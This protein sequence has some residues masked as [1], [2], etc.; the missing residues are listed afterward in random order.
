[1][2]GLSQSKYTTKADELFKDESYFEAIPA[3]QKAYTSESSAVQKARIVFQ[4]AESYR[5]TSQIDQARQW[6]EKSINSKHPDPMQYYYFAEMLKRK[7]DLDG[8]KEHYMNFKKRKPNDDRWK[9]GLKSLELAKKWKEDPSRYIVENVLPIN[10]SAR[11]FSPTFMDKKNSQIVFTSGR[12]GSSGDAVDKR[13][14]ENFTDLWVTLQDKKGKWSEP[15][16]VEG[17]INTEHNEGSAVFDYKRKDM[18]FTRCEYEKKEYKGCEIYKSMVLNGKFKDPV[19]VTE[20]SGTNEGKNTYGHPAISKKGDALVFASDR[21]GGV[22]GKDLWIIT[23]DKRTKKWSAPKNMG[24]KVNT[25]G[26]EMYPFI[27]SDGK[28]YFS[29]DGHV[30]M[31]GLDIFESDYIGNYRWGNVKNME[32]P[33]NSEEDDYGI[34]FNK[35][36][37]NGYFSSSRSG[38]RGKDDIYSFYLPPLEFTLQG[39]VTDKDTKAGIDSC[40]IRLVGSN[41]ESFTGITNG[42]GNY[43]FAENGSRDR[44]VKENTSYSIQV[45]KDGYLVAKDQFSTVGLDESTIFDLSFI[46][47]NAKEEK[48]IEMPEVQYAVGSYE[49]LEQSK[50]S[51][52]FLYDILKNNPT[53]VVEL[54]AHTDARG[55]D[56]SNMEL[57]QKRAESCVNYLASKGIPQQR[58]KAK[59]YG[60]SMPRFPEAE[61]E[62]MSSEAEK[63]KAH[64]LNRRTE[65]FILKEKYTP[66]APTQE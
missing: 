29:S 52:N 27:N 35:L 10:S 66:P 20:I 53:I 58:M 28:L 38:G 18:Y 32:Y 5:L 30:G 46:L 43:M 25:K 34:V 57:S 45:S 4:I 9:T 21:P 33:I 2:V 56:A 1:M 16:P 65:F 23:F 63:E 22:G 60:E 15:V 31:G 51:L 41:G 36:K 61:I 47:Q 7:G 39:K 44:F 14:G 50:D 19:L 49:L 42:S 6:Y 3:Y 54:R 55:D 62:A 13:T 12:A 26:D 37:G 40:S 11:D 17:L 64:Q 8:A 24:S 48:A 59:G